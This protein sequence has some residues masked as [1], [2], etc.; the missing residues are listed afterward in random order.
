MRSLTILLTLIV[1]LAL[2]LS[3]ARAEDYESKR[4]QEDFVE[5]SGAVI[6]IKIDSNYGKV[7]C[8]WDDAAPAWIDADLNPIALNGAYADKLTA[9]DMQNELNRMNNE[10]MDDRYRG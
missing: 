6:R 10:T 7:A 5:V 1:A 2:S 4:F 3:Q 9:R 8:F